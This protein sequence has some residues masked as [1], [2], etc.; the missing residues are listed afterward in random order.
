MKKNAIVSALVLS[1]VLSACGKEKTKTE[2]VD[3]PQ[4]AT[5]LQKTKKERDDL[6]KL[7]NADTVKMAADLEAA[8]A[9]V[10]D[11]TKQLT[12]KKGEL[13]KALKDLE[14]AK[15][16][17]PEQVKELTAKVEKLQAQVTTL[18]ADLET[19]KKDKEALTV[20]VE[21]AKADENS[22]KEILDYAI[23]HD[24]QSRADI[25]AALDRDLI[26]TAEKIESL[27]Q[28]ETNIKDQITAQAQVII[29]IRDRLEFD[30]KNLKDK[31]AQLEAAVK[32]GEL[33]ADD[34]VYQALK[35]YL[36]ASDAIAAE[37]K[38]QTAATAAAEGLRVEIGNIEKDLAKDRTDL[39]TLNAE[40][41]DLATAGKLDTPRAR[42]LST[43]IKTKKET[44]AKSE[45]TLAEKTT[46]RSAEDKKVT[47]SKARAKDLKAQQDESLKVYT[48]TVIAKDREDLKE[49]ETAMD[50]LVK[51]LKG[52]QTKSE[53]AK[54]TK[55]HLDA[56]KLFFTKRLAPVA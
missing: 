23:A 21:A 20:L 50:A 41:L 48:D 36:E 4:T 29:N 8:N 25:G 43:L 27:A 6:L 31:F 46:A 42:E 7:V 52:N 2:Y 5:E 10:S 54:K 38:I 55:T 40:L 3:N 44:I 49:A 53:E 28:Q 39:A 18:T 19:A 1:V 14:D 37:E 16:N 15:K 26:E 33:G 13:D 34:A 12:D 32:A 45:T 51:D 9:K 11:L 30:S 24:A 56:L 47:D 35:T 17:S 22:F